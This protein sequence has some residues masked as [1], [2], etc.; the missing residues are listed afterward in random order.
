MSIRSFFTALFG[1]RHIEPEKISCCIFGLGNP[2]EDY[3]FNR[4]NIGFRVVDYIERSFTDKKVITN[5]HA[6]VTIGK[7][8][9]GHVI[10]TVKPQTFMNRSGDAVSEVLQKY[11]TTDTKH[12][13]V[14]DDFNIPLG[15]IRFRRDGSHGGHNGLKSIIEGIGPN[16]P[17]LRIGIGPLQAGTPVIDFVLG[18][19]LPN[20]ETVLSSL[21]PAINEALLHFITEPIDTVM[22]TYN[23]HPALF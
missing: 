4:H 6:V 17:R 2:G 22:N 13:I 11:A 7:T 19:F 5:G 1:K 18:N 20:E 23:K 10:A 8:G 9:K 15:T 3:H 14:V 16:F 12:I 21:F